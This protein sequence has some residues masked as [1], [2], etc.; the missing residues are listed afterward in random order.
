MAV[1]EVVDLAK[2]EVFPIS[3]QKAVNPAEKEGRER[4]R[5]KKQ[6]KGDRIGPLLFFY[7][8]K[9]DIIYI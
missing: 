2:E 4:N 1:L 3:H 9:D 8:Q 7:Q 5:T 6:S